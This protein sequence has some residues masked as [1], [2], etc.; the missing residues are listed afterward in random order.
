MG[1]IDQL[2]PWILQARTLISSS[3]LGRYVPH[4]SAF[5]TGSS[6]QSP[7]PILLFSVPVRNMS[8]QTPP[9]PRSALRGV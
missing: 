4:A 1:H 8:L 5:Q 9:T 6:Q 3:L 2:E 7:A